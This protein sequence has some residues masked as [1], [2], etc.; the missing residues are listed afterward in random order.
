MGGSAVAA[1]RARR[2]RRAQTGKCAN[3]LP[4]GAS[5]TRRYSERGEGRTQDVLACA[6]FV[7]AASDGYL[8]LDTWTGVAARGPGGAIP[9]GGLPGG[10]PS[11]SGGRPCGCPV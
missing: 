3:G 5:V 6:R 7:P 2:L 8:V 9:T 11:L 10:F 4:R 1:P